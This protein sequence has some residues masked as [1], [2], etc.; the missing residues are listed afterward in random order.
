MM[1]CRQCLSLLL[2][3]VNMKC[4]GISYLTKILRKPMVSRGNIFVKPYYH[5][6]LIYYLLM[7]II[8]NVK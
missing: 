4:M 5:V 1:L 2:I 3:L 6:F 7:Q 8:R